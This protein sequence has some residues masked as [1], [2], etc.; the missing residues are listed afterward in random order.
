VVN[1]PGRLRQ[2]RWARLAAVAGVVALAVT[3]LSVWPWWLR[4]KASGAEWQ[5]SSAY[6]GWKPEGRLGWSS[7]EAFFHTQREDNP[8]LIVD[9]GRSRDLDRIRVVNR[10]HTPERAL[11]LEIEGSEDRVHWVKLAERTQPFAVWVAEVPGTEARYLRFR[12]PRKTWLHLKGIQ[13]L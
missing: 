10:D 13:V 2:Q 12:V 11:P 7:A 3:L 4:N 1:G 9:L 5:A 6:P 8:W